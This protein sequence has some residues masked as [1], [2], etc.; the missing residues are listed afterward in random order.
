MDNNGFSAEQLASRGQK[1][2]EDKLKI[3][4]EAEHW[5]E[6]VAI[7]VKTGEFFVAP[8]LEEALE[9]ARKKYPDEYFHF[10]RIDSQPLVSYCATRRS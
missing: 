6:Y 5:G 9:K 10:V 3:K 8:T 2:Y 1:I 7:Y 4:L